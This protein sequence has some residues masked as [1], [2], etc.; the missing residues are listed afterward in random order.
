[1]QAALPDVLQA[2]HHL[3]LKTALH[4]GGAWPQRLA[5]ALPYLD[6]V[7]FD[8]KTSFDQ[9]DALTCCQGSGKAASESLRRLAD[10]SVPFECRTT[11]DPAFVGPDQV[12]SI[13]QELQSLGVQTYALQECYDA[14]RHPLQTP[15]LA[16]DFLE[17]IRGQMPQL[18]VRSSSI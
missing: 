10:S 5:E 15:C 3:G 4:T 9:Y 12:R 8:V 16:P 1:M 13:V 17:E 2:V 18:I 6:W 7:G 14:E 11:L